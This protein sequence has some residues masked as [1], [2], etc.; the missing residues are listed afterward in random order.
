MAT[1][2][3]VAAAAS[4]RVFGG[5]DEDPVLTVATVLESEYVLAPRFSTEPGIGR[6]LSQLAAD[7]RVEVL[8]DQIYFLARVHPGRNQAFVLDWKA[9]PEPSSAWG[10]AEAPGVS[11][12]TAVSSAVS[13]ATLL[14]P[15]PSDAATRAIE[16]Y[17]DLRRLAPMAPMGATSPCWTL[18]T[19]V[20]IPPEIQHLNWRFAPGG[21]SEL[22]W[23]GSLLARSPGTG[24][25]RL[26]ESI[27]GVVSTT[28]GGSGA[29]GARRLAVRSCDPEPRGFYLLL[30][31]EPSR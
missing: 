17:V 27:E 14:Y 15:R 5:V 26:D 1:Y 16:G 31:V 9:L 29:S 21:P 25:A 24:P 20:P 30:F 18:W 23:D 2:A 28:S 8:H 7:P 6:L 22:W 11:S 13:S 12:A 3:P 19:D 4:Q 10:S